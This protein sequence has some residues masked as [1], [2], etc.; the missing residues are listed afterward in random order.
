M[1]SASGGQSRPPFAKYPKNDFVPPKNKALQIPSCCF[2]FPGAYLSMASRKKRPASPFSTKASQ[3]V[4]SAGNDRN[5]TKSRKSARFSNRQG[6][7]ASASPL[8]PSQMF[9]AEV[10]GE[11][12]VE[13]TSLAKLVQKKQ[14]DRALVSV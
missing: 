4:M 7:E 3:S 11:K 13:L 10:D 9:F 6:S 2:P 12:F 5:P 8:I 14:G 1:D